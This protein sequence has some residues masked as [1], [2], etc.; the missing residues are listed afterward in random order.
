M[1]IGEIAR[2]AGCLAGTVRFYEKEGLIEEAPRTA[3]NYRLYTRSDLER[4]KFILHC[5]RHGISIEDIKR[6][7]ALRDNA[8]IDC[9]FAHEIVKRQLAHVEKELASLQRLHEELLKLKVTSGCGGGKCAI[10]ARLESFEDCPYCRGSDT[11]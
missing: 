5:R 6:L 4:L 2:Q 11:P 1:R 9:D 8:D 10:L 3:A 7:L